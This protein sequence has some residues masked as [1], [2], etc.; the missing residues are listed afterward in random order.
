MSQVDSTISSLHMPAFLV[1]PGDDAGG[2][3]YRR[4]Y[5]T[6]RLMEQYMEELVPMGDLYVSLH[7]FT[8]DT[9]YS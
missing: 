5:S 1:W 2:I 3:F 9:I 4:V 6:L 7:V 8:P